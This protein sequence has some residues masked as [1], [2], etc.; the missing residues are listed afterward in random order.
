MSE[1]RTNLTHNFV[2]AG[3]LHRPSSVSQDS[4]DVSTKEQFVSIEGIKSN[5]DMKE[6]G[7]ATEHEREKLE[8]MADTLFSTLDLGLALKFHEKSGDW[9]AVIQNKITHEVVKEVP[10]KYVLDLRV[11]LKEMIGF[12]LDKKV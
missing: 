4:M 9:Y 12:F 5:E 6:Q 3:M 8:K 7:A 10:P 1:F 11:Q 2:G